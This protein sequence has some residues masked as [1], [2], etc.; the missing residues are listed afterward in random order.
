MNFFIS[1][2]LLDPNR[3][4][5]GDGNESRGNAFIEDIGTI[6]LVAIKQ[7][8]ECIHDSGIGEAN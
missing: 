5:R 7:V 3:A 4:N 1:K 8:D 6:K 2:V